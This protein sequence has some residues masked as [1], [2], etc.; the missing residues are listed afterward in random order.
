MEKL[1][2]GL[3]ELRDSPGFAKLAGELRRGRRRRFGL[4]HDVDLFARADGSV[5]CPA[6][7]RRDAQGRFGRLQ[8]RRL[9]ADSG[10]VGPRGQGR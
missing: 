1:V 3:I 4:F 6:R 7:L 10:D 2:A 9:E 5:I 8:S